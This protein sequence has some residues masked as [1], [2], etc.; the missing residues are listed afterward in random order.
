MQINYITVLEWFLNLELTANDLRRFLPQLMEKLQFYHFE[1][2]FLHKKAAR[3]RN[4]ILRVILVALL[5][6]AIDFWTPRL[7]LLTGTA[8][9]SRDRH[10]DVV[11]HQ[12]KCSSKCT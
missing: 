7:L 12:Y 1:S 3:A 8:L 9:W 6:I 4:S 5:H 2:H 10:F 11:K